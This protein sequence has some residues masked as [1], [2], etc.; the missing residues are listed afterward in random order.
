MLS[1][2]CASL[3]QA[4]CSV[5]F[6]INSTSANAVLETCSVISKKVATIFLFRIFHQA[7]TFSKTQTDDNC[8]FFGIISIY[9]HFFTWVDIAYQIKRPSVYLHHLTRSSVGAEVKISE[10]YIEKKLTHFQIYALILFTQ[11]TKAARIFLTVMCSS[12]WNI[13]RM[14]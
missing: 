4:N 13:F 14:K 12:F 6:W 5:A 2:D 8:F 9:P 7:D 11:V 3:E 10:K 1:L